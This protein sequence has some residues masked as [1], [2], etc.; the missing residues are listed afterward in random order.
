[1][2][3]HVKR[4][5]FFLFCGVYQTK[6][7]QSDHLHLLLLLPVYKIEAFIAH[8]NFYYIKANIKNVYV[9][10]NAKI[11][12]PIWHKC[13]SVETKKSTKCTKFHWHRSTRISLSFIRQLFTKSRYIN[14]KCNIF[15]LF[16]ICGNSERYH[17]Y[18][19]HIEN[20]GVFQIYGRLWKSC[21]WKWVKL[22]HSTFKENLVK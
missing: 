13:K 4:D 12:C 22:F 2:N 18:Y 8:V 3:M 17:F 6:M 16:H 7:Y 9:P 11:F 5:D 19:F 20:E 21:Q 1:M 14:G 10:K 15:R